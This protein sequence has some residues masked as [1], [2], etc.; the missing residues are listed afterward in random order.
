MAV[1]LHHVGH[2][3]IV[4]SFLRV[5][6]HQNDVSSVTHCRGIVSPGMQAPP[7]AWCRSLVYDFLE[8]GIS[9]HQLSNPQSRR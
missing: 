3:N 4:G 1:C 7:L 6:G 2:C 8:S 5:H 9:P